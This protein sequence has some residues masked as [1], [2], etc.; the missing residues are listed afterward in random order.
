MKKGK[1]RFI[2]YEQRAKS[3]GAT[4]QSS[5]G[6]DLTA[7]GTDGSN[8][9]F[10]NHARNDRNPNG[11]QNAGSFVILIIWLRHFADTQWQE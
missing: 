8:A 6:A 2:N 5:S 10:S 9:K 4:N 7:N 11:E 1:Y 3:F